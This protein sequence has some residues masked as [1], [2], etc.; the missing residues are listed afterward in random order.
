MTKEKNIDCMKYRKSTHLAGIDV[1]AI[2]AEKGNCILTIKETYFAK[3]IDVSGNKTDGYF[4]EFEEDVK[5]LVLNSTNRKSISD[6]VKSLKNCT[7]LESRN[8]GN[9][10]GL[11]IELTF[12]ANVKMMGKVTGGVRVAKNNVNLPPVTDKNAVELLNKCNNKEELK[13]VWDSLSKQ[14]KDLPTVLK[15]KDELKNKFIN[16]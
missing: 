7:P 4:V 12:D 14:E 8:I 15:L 11:K 2:I 5:P 6:I 16:D 9:W 3:G 10:T 1:E 13:N